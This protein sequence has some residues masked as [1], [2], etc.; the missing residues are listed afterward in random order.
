[1]KRI[2]YVCTALALATV[3]TLT[4]VESA[5]ASPAVRAPQTIQVQLVTMNPTTGYKFLTS[6]TPVAASPNMAPSSGSATPLVTDYCFYTVRAPV[7]LTGHV[8]GYALLTSCT[9]PPTVC[10]TTAEMYVLDPYTHNWRATLTSERYSYRCVPPAVTVPTSST[11]S[12]STITL[13]FKTE[14]I[15]FVDYKG[16][17][18]TAGKVSS[19]RTYRC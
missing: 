4:L 16:A 15:L 2:F 8:F 5:G 12:G 1:M 11:C 13:T 10:K 7:K 18:G 14:G 3:S 19:T 17:I 9:Y 6:S